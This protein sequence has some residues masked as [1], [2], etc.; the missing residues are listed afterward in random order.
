MELMDLLS[1]P[2]HILLDTGRVLS[3]SANDKLNRAGSR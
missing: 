2:K 1:V 3:D